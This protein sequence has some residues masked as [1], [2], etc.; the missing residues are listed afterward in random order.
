MRHLHPSDYQVMPWNNGGGMTTEIAVHPENSSLSAKSLIWRVSIAD[1]AA[2][3]PFS[4]FPG[5]DRHIMTIAGHGM[6]LD[7]GERGIIDLTER[8]VPQRFSGDW[9][10]TG[11]LNSGPVRDFNV[12]ADR[13]RVLSALSVERLARPR[14]LTAG[15]G[16]LLAYVVEGEA[17]GAGHLLA[18]GDSLILD[19][20]ESIELSPLSDEA[21]LAIALIRPLPKEVAA[22][23]SPSAGSRRPAP[24]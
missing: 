9:E 23:C 22:G 14:K 13:S 18:S 16:T 24:R 7:A 15:E 6:R 17:T 19:G 4:L 1:V 20:T 5:Y 8:L 12:M 21:T 11:R 3:G 2:D 10:V